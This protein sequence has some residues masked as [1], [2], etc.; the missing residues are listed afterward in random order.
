MDFS[1]DVFDC[2]WRKESYRA[3]VMPDT[4]AVSSGPCPFWNI[5]K[6]RRYQNPTP[7]KLFTPTRLF[8]AAALHTRAGG[9]TGRGTA[10]LQRRLCKAL[11]GW[12]RE[13][14]VSSLFR[15]K[16]TIFIE[17]INPATLSIEVL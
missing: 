10:R 17:A 15:L 16:G 8:R 5:G 13:Q 9:L 3:A 7:E 12:Q 2:D 14:E 6:C 4:G 1:I 11:A